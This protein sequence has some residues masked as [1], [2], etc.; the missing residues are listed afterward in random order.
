MVRKVVDEQVNNKVQITP[1]E[2]EEY[3]WSHLPD[4][5]TTPIVRARHLVVLRKSDLEKVEQSL[6]Q[7]G[8]FAKVRPPH[9]PWAPNATRAATGE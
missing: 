9:F 2:V 6:K 1:E 4:Y 8:D 5:W 3:Y 7:E